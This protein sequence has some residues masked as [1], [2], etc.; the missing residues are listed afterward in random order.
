MKLSQQDRKTRKTLCL[1]SIVAFAALYSLDCFVLSP[2]LR[3]LANNVLFESSFLLDLLSYLGSIAELVA[4]SVSYAVILYSIYRFTLSHSKATVLIFVLAT[5][6]KYT[7]NTVVSWTLEGSVSE[8]LLW[9]GINVLFYTALET[10]QLIVIVAIANRVITRQKQQDRILA[11]TGKET[12]IYPFR[13]VY[14]KENCLMRSALAAAVVVF[15]SKVF[16]RLVND[17]YFVLVGGFPKET[18]TWLM[19]L[20]AYLASVLFGLLCYITVILTLTRLVK[21]PKA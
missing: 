9:D 20:A 14:D 1:V 12:A 7:A 13:S 16:G 3:A 6:F 2:T 15:I 4:V 18:S 21:R 10:I 17:V 19:M 11:G 5:V 8:D